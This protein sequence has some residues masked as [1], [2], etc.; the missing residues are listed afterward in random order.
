MNEALDRVESTI[1]EARSEKQL[2]ITELNTESHAA[3][4]IT[5]TEQSRYWLHHPPPCSE[6]GHREWTRSPDVWWIFQP[7]GGA[8]ELIWGQYLTSVRSTSLSA[9]Q[10]E[11]KLCPVQTHRHPHRHRRVKVQGLVQTKCYWGAVLPV[12]SQQGAR[13]P[14]HSFLSFHLRVIR[15]GILVRSHVARVL[16]NLLTTLATFALAAVIKAL[17]V[18][19]SVTGRVGQTVHRCCLCHFLMEVE[20]LD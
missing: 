16:H 20:K 5:I 13:P 8:D 1:G 10:N 6:W 2:I 3:D 4:W 15:P 12:S 14:A 19:S 9:N 11:Q 18:W 7:K 17:L